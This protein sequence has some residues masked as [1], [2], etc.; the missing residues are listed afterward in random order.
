MGRIVWRFSR[1]AF[2]VAMAACS[3]EEGTAGTVT[4]TDANIQ[5]VSASAYDQSC[6]TAADCVGVGEGNACY[7]CVLA[8][9]TAAINS[10][11]KSRYDADVAKTSGAAHVR[12]VTCNCPAQFAPCCIQGK[13]HADLA[14]S[15]A[16]P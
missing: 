13:C 12:S 9:A 5:T 10:A 1:A 3:S 8:C 16:T 15:D 6:R 4:C 7:P 14:C 11:A 2:A